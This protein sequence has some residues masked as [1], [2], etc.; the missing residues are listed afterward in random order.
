MGSQRLR[1]DLATDQQQSTI[2]GYSP[3]RPLQSIS[4]LFHSTE[5][6]LVKVTLTAMVLSSGYDKAMIRSYYTRPLVSIFANWSFLPS[7]WKHFL[8]LAFESLLPRNLSSTLL[9]TYSHCPFWDL[10]P[11][12]D[13][14]LKHFC[15]D[16][17]FMCKWKEMYLV[18]NRVIGWML[19]MMWLE[20]EF[21][22]LSESNSKWQRLKSGKS[23]SKLF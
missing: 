20:D 23:L 15:W 22:Q 10:A 6:A 13:Q 14:E 17:N 1:H 2:F 18:V 3:W 9:T 7:F 21:F 16:L 4:Y 19:W 8:Q 12:G 5:N 11:V